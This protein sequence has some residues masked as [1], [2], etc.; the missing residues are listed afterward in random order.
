MNNMAI[1]IYMQQNRV[2]MLDD[3][4]PGCNVAY[5]SLEMPYDDCFRRTLARMADVPEYGIRDAK[6]GQAEAKGLSQAC[7]FIKKYP[8]QFDIIDVPRGFSV[9]NLEV[10]FEE[11]KSE[12]V[13]DVIFIDY[14]GLMEDINND[15]DDWLAI[16][17]LAGKIHEFARVHSVPIVTA[18]Q[19]NRIDPTFR[20]SSVKSIGMHRIGRS[21]LIA[22]HATMILQIETREDEETHDD[23]IYHVIKNRYGQSNKSHSIYKNLSKC[24]IIDRPYDVDSITA[25]SSNDDIS[26]EVSEILGEL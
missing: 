16:G 9:E 6:L 10:M 12:Y 11:I 13:P 24:S 15:N 19:L 25:W 21:A 8:Y 2:D 5:F 18:V 14:L 3:F 22:T 1:Q 17:Q 23:F 20:K 7:K 26:S 4:G